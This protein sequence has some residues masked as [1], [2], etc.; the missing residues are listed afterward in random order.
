MKKFLA[1]VVLLACIL[2]LFG[3]SASIKTVEKDGKSFKINTKSYTIS[4]VAYTYNYEILSEDT[5][6]R[7]TIFYPDGSTY[8]WEKYGYMGI[9]N[10][11][12]DFRED[13]YSSGEIL[14]SIINEE[15]PKEKTKSEK[16]TIFLAAFL[17]FLAA[18]FPRQILR[19]RLLYL[20]LGLET[21]ESLVRIVRI[22]SIIGIFVCF[23][24]ALS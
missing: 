21:P 5:S 9:G 16:A 24:L 19:P 14:C 20:I 4:D 8:S 1:F 15:S 2:A 12:G 3:C 22:T 13:L 18:L 23:I 10:Y 7:I 11:S 6:Y 17:F